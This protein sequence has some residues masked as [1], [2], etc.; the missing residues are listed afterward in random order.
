[1]NKI[2]KIVI[3]VIIAIWIFGMGYE[4][5]VYLETKKAIANPAPQVTQ[6]DVQQ[7]Q[8]QQ[9]QPQQTQPQQTPPVIQTVPSTQP[10]TQPSTEAPS[11]DVPQSTQ[12]AATDPSTWTTDQIVQNLANAVNQTKAYTGPVNVHRT[13]T[14]DIAVTDV[15][16]GNVVKN[17]VNGLISDIGGPEDEMLAFNGGIA[18]NSEGES[19]PM[20]LPAA[21]NFA[22]TPAGVASATATA[23]GDN[24]KIQLNLAQEAASMGQVPPHHSSCI[25]YMDISTFGITVV[26]ITRADTT[27]KGTT[28]TAVIN[29]AGNV[30]SYSYDMP[31]SISFTG[32]KGPISADVAI[33][34][35][36]VETWEVQWAA[37]AAN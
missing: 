17:L 8:P 4:F 18:V 19:M 31:L 22:L 1:M 27:Y 10:S 21:G 9:T 23:E 32:S 3:A 36:Q 30:V 14:L 5:G 16:G 33:D 34:A 26:D 11:A 2:V 28:I 35:H 25:G 37:S 12:S 15:T 6:G 29:S 13:E 20:L 24:V 7:T